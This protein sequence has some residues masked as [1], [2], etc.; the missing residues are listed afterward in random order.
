MSFVRLCHSYIVEEFINGSDVSIC[1]HVVIVDIVLILVKKTLKCFIWLC[2]TSISCSIERLYCTFS[3]AITSSR[4]HTLQYVPVSPRK[5]V[6]VMFFFTVLSDPYPWPTGSYIL[7]LTLWFSNPRFSNTFERLTVVTNRNFNFM[8]VYKDSCKT[9]LD[10]SFEPWPDYCWS[11]LCV[12]CNLA[13]LHGC[14]FG[15]KAV[16]QSRR[17]NENTFM[18][19]KALWL[20]LFVVWVTPCQDLHFLRWWAFL[21]WVEMSTWYFLPP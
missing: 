11:A 17:Q 10:R 9:A 3:A 16:W 7:L 1:D 18:W 19:R 6:L 15:F 21:C 5:A 13:Y 8:S 20:Y 12:N 2:Q 4:Y 14:H